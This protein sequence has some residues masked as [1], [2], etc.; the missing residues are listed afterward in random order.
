MS[1]GNHSPLCI[2]FPPSIDKNCTTL[3][4]GSMPGVTSLE[5]QQYYAHPQNRFWPM[6]AR[7][8]EG[9]QEAPAAYEERLSM[10]LRHHIALWDS[11][12]SCVRE[13]SLDTSIRE[14]HGNDF[15]QL[16]REYPELRTICFN[17]AKSA[18]CFRRFNRELWKHPGSH[19]FCSMPSTSPANA[20]W[21]LPQL[22]EAWGKVIHP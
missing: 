12:G 16:F 8:L 2:G 15:S 10:L 22:L 7:L 19:T 21:R 13:G 14:A 1:L 11:I 9:K 5:K 17:G 18:A 3:V 6:M 20:R 4:L